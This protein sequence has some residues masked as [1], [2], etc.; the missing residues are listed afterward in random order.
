MLVIAHRSGPTVYPEQTVDSALLAVK[1]GADMV[2]IDLRFSSDGRII[3]CHDDNAERVFGID[4]SVN[5]MTAEEFASLT[6]KDE[7]LHHGH[8]FADYIDA[9]VKPLLLHIKEGGENIN[10]ILDFI[11]SKGYLENIIMGVTRPDDVARVKKYGEN[12]PVLAFIKNVQMIDDCIAEGAEFIRLWQGWVAEEYVEKIHS[13]G[14][15]VW[16]MAG[17]SRN[18]DV[19]YIDDNAIDYLKKIGIDGL[20]INDIGDFLKT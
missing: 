15:K 19:G 18:G 6:H 14:R 1:N 8:L 20:L 9:G 2:E 7:P 17:S 5:E 10:A 12:I 4:R 11:V 3:V 13:A 16:V